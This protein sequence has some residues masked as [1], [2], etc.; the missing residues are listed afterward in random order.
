MYSPQYDCQSS[1]SISDQTPSLPTHITYDYMYSVTRADHTLCFSPIP[2]DQD[3]D[4]FC[5]VIYSMLHQGPRTVTFE[6]SGDFKSQ[7]AHVCK[8]LRTQSSRLRPCAASQQDEAADPQD[9]AVSQALTAIG[10]SGT[11]AVSGAALCGINLFGLFKWQHLQDIQLAVELNAVLILLDALLFVPS[12]SIPAALLEPVQPD[13]SSRSYEQQ[14]QPKQFLDM[15]VVSASSAWD[16]NSWRL[17]LAM[18]RASI[19]QPQ[20]QQLPLQVRFESAAL[21]THGIACSL[22]Q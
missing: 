7:S 8:L 22:S 20:L 10:L 9:I 17:M 15:T 21:C 5:E 12:Y 2:C 19:R 4:K 6:R 1:D 3:D 11:I 18:L 13:S 14:Q 16:P